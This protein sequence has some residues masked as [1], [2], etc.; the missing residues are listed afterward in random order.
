MSALRSILSS[1]RM[2]FFALGV[3]AGS[4]LLWV[5]ATASDW[6]SSTRFVSHV[7]MLALVLAGLAMLAGALAD[8]RSPDE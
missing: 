4:V 5:V 3:I 7:S 1:E 2:V 8:L 6:V